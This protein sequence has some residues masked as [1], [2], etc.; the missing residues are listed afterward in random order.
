[1]ELQDRD[2]VLNMASA[3]HQESP[4]FRRRHFASVKVDNLFHYVVQEGGGFVLTTADNK[5]I[6][7][8]VGLVS[9]HLF[10]FDKYA[11]DVVVYIAPEHRGGRAFPSLVKAFEAWAIDNGVSEI[12][13]GISTEILSERT[14]ALYQA[15]GYNLSS[16]GTLK[17]V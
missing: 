6:G 5:V 11:V 2:A 13:L 8:I 4:R 14:V 15:L 12:S 10:G 17:Y 1:M 3:L 7:M 9:E 16:Y